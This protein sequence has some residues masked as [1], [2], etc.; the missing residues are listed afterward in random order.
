M[1]KNQNYIS[2]N[3]NYSYKFCIVRLDNLGLE[4]YLFLGIIY[5]IVLSYFDDT[6]SNY[7]LVYLIELYLNNQNLTYILFLL[8]NLI[9]YI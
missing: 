8:L 2:Y 9:N 6:N 4:N 1:E 5:S 3:V 7:I